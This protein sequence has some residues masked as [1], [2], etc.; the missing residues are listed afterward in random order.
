MKK[1]TLIITLL[2]F[3]SVL[4]KLNAQ[5]PEIDSLENI[6]HKHTQKDT[7]RVNLLNETAGKL[8][9]INI[10]KTIKYIKE[11]EE[12]ANKINFSKG[13][14]ESLRLSGIYYHNKSNYRKALEYYQKALKIFEE[15]GDKKEIAKCLYNIG[16]THYYQENDSQALKYFQ[17]S[18]EIKKEIGD[19]Q[20]ISNCLYG[21]GN[22]YFIQSNYPQALE[23]YQKSLKTNDK[24]EKKQG[25]SDCL[26]NI[27][28]IHFIQGNYSQALEYYYKALK[29][30]E[31]LGDKPRI[32]DCFNCIGSTHR[33]QGNYPQALEYSQKALRIAEEIA[34]NNL[35]SYCLEGIG[36]IHFQQGNYP[37]ALEYY[38]NS[39]KIKKEFGYKFDI[40]YSYKSIGAVYLKTNNY[41]EALDYTVKSL[42]IAVELE[43]LDY[44]KEIYK[45]LSDIYAG[46]NNYKKAYENHVLYK[47]LNDSIFSEKN[48]KKLTGLEYQYKYEKEKQAIKLKQQKKDAVHDEEAKRQ[49]IMRNSFIAGFILMA[50][51]VLVVL[52]SFLQKREANRILFAQK[53]E[54]EEKNQQ[55][56]LHKDEIQ[57]FV[58][59]L[60][61]A[62]N[63]KDKFFSIIAHDLKSPFTAILGFSKLLLKNHKK[64]SEEEREKLIKFINSSSITTLKLLENLFTWA[65]SQSGKIQFSPKSLNLK[66]ILSD[67]IDE[68]KGPAERKEIQLLNSVADNKMVFVDKNMIYS[69]LRN[70][71]SNAIKFT[72]KNGKVIVS[73]KMQK[74]KNFIEISVKDTGVG[75]PEVLINDLFR[76]DKNTS[77]IGTENEK[78]TGLGLILCK[79]FIEKHGGKIRV[80]SIMTEGSNFI[81]TLPMKQ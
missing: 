55:L 77:T 66:T 25:I 81:F 6:L 45:Q 3:S 23:Y 40:C 2:I 20:G 56:E 11:A 5:T 32:S 39:L 31:E 74:D 10:D 72:Q 76:I 49:K 59:E 12:L 58:E 38:K 9:L 19:K 8:F 41:A 26:T 33:A 61:K 44:Q 37:Q 34:D 18:L 13:N 78:G 15:L 64:Y 73:S 22:I 30:A 63:T 65:R 57:T 36:E 7:I 46:T 70:L 16:N 62:N 27:G 75:I 28:L 1:L 80:E 67:V 53:I 69:V 35:I 42:K 4:L 54:I 14:A 47:E 79:E 68:N 52:R 29:I 43:L 21:I 51:F 48:I 17:K 71:I 50:L 60:E 24:P